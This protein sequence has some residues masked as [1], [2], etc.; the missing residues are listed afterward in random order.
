MIE[1]LRRRNEAPCTY[2]SLDGR[3]EFVSALR[4]IGDV[5]R[6]ISSSSLDILTAFHD[7]GVRLSADNRHFGRQQPVDVPRDSPANVT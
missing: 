1:W 6:V 2:R 5:E 4:V 3:F 7:E